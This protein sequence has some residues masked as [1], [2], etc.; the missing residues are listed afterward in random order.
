MYEKFFA[1]M[2]SRMQP[3]LALAESNKKAMERLADVQKQ[4]MTEVVN[5]SVIQLQEL[6]RCSDAQ[7]ALDLQLKYYKELEAQMMDSAE[8]SIA[9]INEARDSFVEAIE[10]SARKTAE[11]VE[12]VVKSAADAK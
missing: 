7:T 10:E 3:V 4:S 5:A 1:D 2:Q 6:S 9:A 12:A 11:E 8:K